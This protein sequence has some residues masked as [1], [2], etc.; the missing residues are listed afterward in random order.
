MRILNKLQYFGTLKALLLKPLIVKS[1]PIHAQIEPTTYCNLRCSFCLRDQYIKNPQHMRF[2]QFKQI[3]D[4]LNLKKLALNGSGEPFLNPD[5]L[6]MI[7]YAKSKG[8]SVSIVSNFTVIKKFIKEVVESDLDEIRVSIDGA[9]K[10]T[11][12]KARNQDFFEKILESIREINRYKKELNKT[13]PRLRFQVVLTQTA[14]DEMKDII[15]LAESLEVH[16]ISFKPVSTIH[17]DKP[18]EKSELYLGAYKDIEKTR[19]KLLEIKNMLPKNMGSDIPVTLKRLKAL[20]FKLYG[21]GEDLQEKRICY[22]PWFSVYILAD[23]QVRLCCAMNFGGK[24][25]SMGN[26]FE[27]DFKAIW[28]N[29]KFQHVR[30]LARQ[31][32][33]LPYQECKHCVPFDLFNFYTVL[34]NVLPG[35]NT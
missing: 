17:D 27:E 7:R 15:K 31:G 33:V 3:V 21:I 34:Q 2:E 23:G 22:F 14:Y 9:T 32:K 20:W 1:L 10:E 18:K 24:E 30:R 26:V 29:E 35:L 11:Y 16:A 19:E 28:N 5:L 8:I 12:I 13:T 4:S 6:K 25:R